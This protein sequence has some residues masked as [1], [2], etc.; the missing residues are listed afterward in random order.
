MSK[1]LKSWLLAAMFALPL[2]GCV[3]RYVK[4][5]DPPCRLP[6]WP[7]TNWDVCDA[8]DVACNIAVAGLYIRDAEAVF[9]ALKVCNVEF[10]PYEATSPG[11]SP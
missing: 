7:V 8:T 2:S 1:K 4:V 10:G 11:T 5:S 6:T 9:D 3:T